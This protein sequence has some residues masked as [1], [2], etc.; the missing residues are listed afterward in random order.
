MANVFDAKTDL[1][2]TP[3][4]KNEILTVFETS[5]AASTG[6]KKGHA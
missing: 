1:F 5:A 3:D 2:G 4:T 6:T